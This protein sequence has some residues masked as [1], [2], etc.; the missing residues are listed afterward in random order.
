[1]AIYVSKNAFLSVGG[2]DLSNHVKQ[3][4]LNTGNEAVDI[5]AMSNNS[6]IS[7][8][9]LKTWSVEV[10]FYQDFSASVDVAL[11]ALVGGAASAL[12]MK[13]VNTTAS[14]TNPSFTGN[15]ILENYTPIA[16]AVGE[17]AIIKATFKAGGDLT[18]ATA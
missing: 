1:M 17:A 7:T 2:T 10:D 9:G 4:T 5:T 14:A 18:R 15:A 3:L 16:G 12:V 6:R 8:N 11:S 13:P